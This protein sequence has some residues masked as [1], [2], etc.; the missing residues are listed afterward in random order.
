LQN[1]NVHSHT[2]GGLK[3]EV[4]HPGFQWKR[5]GWLAERSFWRWAWRFREPPPTTSSEFFRTYAK[6]PQRRCSSLPCACTVCVRAP[7]WNNFA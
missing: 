1:H 7:Y 4:Q 6:S 3:Y 5:V 2:V